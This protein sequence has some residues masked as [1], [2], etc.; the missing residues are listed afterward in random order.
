MKTP[1]SS[2]LSV[3]QKADKLTLTALAEAIGVSAPSATMALKGKSF[4]NATTAPKFAKF[5]GIT[6]E[7]LQAFKK[8]KVAAKTKT[9]DKP[10]A[11]VTKAKPIRKT[12]QAKVKPTKPAK[13][14]T[15][16]SISIAEAAELAADELAVAVHGATAEQRRV[17]TAVLGG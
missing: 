11:K 12:K 2:A 3:K 17:I 9:V 5:L 14:S 6:V 8:G 15:S 1:L 10:A 16:T 13:A 7:E 4:P